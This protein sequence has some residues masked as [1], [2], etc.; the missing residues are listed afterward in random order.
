MKTKENVIDL[1]RSII[2]KNSKISSYEFM[3]SNFEGF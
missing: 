1:A 3:L 2:E